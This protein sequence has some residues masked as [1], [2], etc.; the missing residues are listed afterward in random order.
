MQ[1]RRGGGD[2][3]LL[4][5][6]QRYLKP[7]QIG[8]PPAAEAGR[9]AYSSKDAECDEAHDDQKEY[10]GVPRCQRRRELVPTQTQDD[11]RP[12][13]ANRPRRLFHLG[14]TQELLTFKLLVV[15]FAVVF[16]AIG[17]LLRVFQ[18]KT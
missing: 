10:V 5:R 12:C 14:G 4:Q 13:D 2:H 16:D 7:L 9:L 8:L 17:Q 15:R 18:F 6:I 1:Q 11:Q 3:F